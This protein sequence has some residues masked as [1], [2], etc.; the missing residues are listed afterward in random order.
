M[1]GAVFIAL[2]DMLVEQQGLATWHKIVDGA[3]TE[4]IYTST[5]NYEDSEMMALVDQ[6]CAVLSLNREQ[7]LRHFGVYLFDFLHKGFPMFADAKADFFSFIES[8]NGV[9]HIEVLKLDEKARTPNI[10]VSRNLDDSAT[11]L[12]HSDR[13]LCYLAEGLLI[14]AANHYGIKIHIEHI[15]CMLSGADQCQFRITEHEQP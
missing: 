14:G 15:A 9:I 3:G 7:A 2:Q 10:S 5:L 13:K 4:G 8:I 11:L 6:V 1:K 12:Y